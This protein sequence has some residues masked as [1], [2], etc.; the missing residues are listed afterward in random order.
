MNVET[1]YYTLSSFCCFTLFCIYNV[2]CADFTRRLS[3]GESSSQPTIA[4]VRNLLLMCVVLRAYHIQ[5]L[6]L[7]APDNVFFSFNPDPTRPYSFWTVIVGLGVSWCSVL[8]INQSITQRYLSCK[9]VRHARMYAFAFLIQFVKID[10]LLKT[11]TMM[12]P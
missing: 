8:C 2:D 6:L 11:E 1:L 9:S 4:K 10:F 12:S 7:F 5:C 3:Q